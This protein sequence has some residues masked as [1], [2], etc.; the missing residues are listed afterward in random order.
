EPTQAPGNGNDGNGNGGDGNGN[1]D[2]NGNGGGDGNTDPGSGGSNPSPVQG[3][4]GPEPQPTTTR[5]GQ[6]NNRPPNLGGNPTGSYNG[7]LDYGDDSGTGSTGNNGGG[8]NGGGVPGDN[9]GPSS[10]NPEQSNAAASP[11]PGIIGA[12]VSLLVLLLVLVALLYKYRRTRRVQSFLIRFTPLKIAPYSKLDRKRSSMG[13]DLMFG[14]RGEQ[15]PYTD[16]KRTWSMNYGSMDNATPVTHPNPVASRRSRTDVPPLL[17]LDISLANSVRSASPTSQ[18]EPS[19]L[20]PSYP[21]MRTPPP[22]RHSPRTS[23]DSTGGLSIASSGVFNPSMITWPMPPSTAN[24]AIG[25]PPG[26]SHTVN[27]VETYDTGP[28]IVGRSTP[29]RYKPIQPAPP[30]NWRKPQDWD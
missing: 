9:G 11:L 24:S 6:G 28:I 25:S 21:N 3:G 23:Q 7:G 22:A 2:G 18:F 10:T 13:S 5:A 30:S 17:E 8:L 26:T 20:S 15:E 16:E 4:A 14:C 1:N 19:P 12:V 29:T 27:T